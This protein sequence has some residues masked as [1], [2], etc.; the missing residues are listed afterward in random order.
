MRFKIASL[1]L[2]MTLS[3]DVSIVLS[4]NTS[5]VLSQPTEAQALQ[6]DVAIQRALDHYHAGKLNE[7]TGLLRGFV[8]S[9]PDSDLINQAYYYLAR[10]HHD[11][12]DP[13]TAIDYLG[14]MT[15]VA[16]SPAS[17]LLQSEILLQMDDAVRAVEQL[18]QSDTHNWTLPERQERY[19]TLAEGLV[20]LDEPQKALY[21]YQQALMIEGEESPRDVLTRIYTLQSDRFSWA[22]LTEVAFMYHDKPVAYLAMLQL[23]W[24]S[25]AAGQKELAQEWASAAMAAP[26]GFAYRE[27]A[28]ALQSQLTDPTQLQRA[29]GI[30][31]PLSGRYAAFGQRVQRGMELA[32]KTFRPHIPVRFIYRDTAGDETVAAQQVAE[33]AISDRVMGIAGPLV[34]N[35]A[36]GATRRANQERTPLLTMSQKQGLAASSLYVFRNSLTPQLQVRALIDYAMEERGFSQ[37]G[38]MSPQTR[39]G[40]NFAAVFREEVMRR[41]GE[42][43][44]EQSYLTDQTD[45]RSQVRLLQG[46]DP[47]APDEEE[48]KKDPDDPNAIAEE[49]E[50][51]PFEALFIPDYADRIS[52]LAPQLAFYGLEGVQLLGP[53]GWNDAE[54][55][56][57][58]RQF[59]EGAVFTDGFFRHSDYPFVQDFVEQYFSQY[60]EEPTILE[61]QGYDIAGILL[62]LLNDSSVR[63]REDLRR[64]LA[65]IQNYPGVTGATRFDFIGEADKILFLLQVQKG[66]IVQI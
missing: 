21:F 65:Q 7:A 43:I 23:G 27:E 29:I 8:I 62:T 25:L 63:S 14:K 58:T 9:Q 41:G 46:L 64:A 50:P 3:L 22:D 48:N 10:I 57:L 39:Q 45:F 55:P 28:L 33:L 53:N 42:I 5:S 60:N 18:L 38:I 24:R 17:I 54:L 47:N 40:E 59:V 6:A 15:E 61:A 31:L 56:R 44:S 13:T 2:C 16:H 26:A 35:A 30:L 66:T 1:L 49:E 32:R 51:P 20:I 36:L 37:F 4:L 52:L 11:L 34:G 12:E 19:L